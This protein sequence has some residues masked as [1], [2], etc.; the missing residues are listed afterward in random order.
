MNFA[1]GSLVKARG[2]EWVVLPQSKGELLMV[3]PL[4]GSEDETTGILLPLENVESAVFPQP[5]FSELGDYRSCRLLREAVRLGFRSGAGPFRSFAR[6]AVEP[7]PYQLVPLLVALKLD[8]VR[9]LI[10]DDVGIGKT[11]EAG[12]IARELLDRGE[13][14]RLAILCPPSL[15]EQWQKELRDKFHIEAVLVLAGTA[16]RL[17]RDCARDQSIFDLHPVVIVS[18]D[19]IKSDRH[20]DD[21]LRTCPELVI[22]DEA[23]TF[24]CGGQGRG[25]VHQRNRLLLGLAADPKRHLVLVTAT[26]HSGKENSF[27]SLLSFLDKDFI[28]LPEDL[29]GQQYEAQRKRLAA[30]FVQRRRA[31]IVHYMKEDT[32]FPSRDDTEVTYSLSPGY[33]KL[34]NKVLS[35]AREIVKDKD[36]NVLRQRVRWWSALALLRSLASSPAAAASTLRSRAATVDFE[37]IKSIDEFG[38]RS[39]MDIDTDEEIADIIPGADTVETGE[40]DPAKKRLLELA[41]EADSLYGS[42]DLKL[43]QAIIEIKKLVQEGYR[44]IVFCRF[45]PTAEYLAD[46]LRRELKEVEVIAV[47]GTLPPSEREERILELAQSPRRVLVATDCLS[48]GINLQQHFD[49]V[50][51]YDL[52]WN[53]TRHEQREGRVD[54]FGQQKTK[55]KVV[56]FYGR[57][58]KI[59]GII[60]EVLIRK[61]KNIRSSLG[62][63]VPVPMSS[64]AVVE[65]IFEGI[66]LRQR[67]EITQLSFEFMEPTKRELFNRWDNA[68]TRE[69]RTRTMFAQE[70]IK[71]EEVAKEFAAMREAMGTSID[72]EVFVREAFAALNANLTGVD[73][74]KI[75]LRSAP[76]LLKDAIG[77]EL[78]LASFKPESVHYLNRT[79][80]AVENLANYVLNSALDAY[81]DSPAKRCG[82]I[83]T[84]QVASRTTVL[85]VRFRYSIITK[86]KDQEHHLLAEDCQVMSFTGAPGKAAWLSPDQTESLIKLQPEANIGEDQARHFLQSTLA[87]VEEIMPHLEQTAEVRA[88]QL[89][90]AHRR[91]RTAARKTGVLFKVVPYLPP[92]ILGL[93][94]YLPKGGLQ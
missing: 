52:S 67:Q 18:S 55:V 58:N 9:I 44:P 92:D 88:Q 71:V 75:D 21:F 50:F 70:S 20:R 23:H 7:R 31:D 66:L 19:F 43:I 38:H 87:N 33:K 45:I 5:I 82:V 74:F 6:I 15:A 22:V 30:H 90:D 57:D 46:N 36:C 91:V 86:E 77:E 16:G 26:P 14:N 85:L 94:L 63:S 42:L 73:P 51:H 65:A 78:L 34:L 12:L 2:R 62:I 56:T 17:E 69:Q 29:R 10:A 64:N 89:L 80:P 41:R 60:L 61:H 59:D 4:G 48:E 1:A 3:R 93:F 76:G 68:S 32:P 27:R 28:N 11:I 13:A 37:D 39:I 72:V 8:P 40:S 53:P 49:A 81:P 24:A 25:A 47:T 79:H 83:R 54:R 35:Y 84:S